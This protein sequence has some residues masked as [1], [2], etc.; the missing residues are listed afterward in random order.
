MDC[1]TKSRAR[2]IPRVFQDGRP[3]PGPLRS[4]EYPKGLPNLAGKDLERVRVDNQ[5]CAFVLDAIEEV[6][7]RGGGSIR[8]NP[9]G[10]STGT[11]H[12]SSAWPVPGSTAPAALGGARCQYQR[13]QH[14]IEE[15]TEWPPAVCHH[16]HLP[17]E[18]EPQLVNGQRVY[19]SK[20]EAEYT[21]PVAFCLAVATS[22]WA[23]RRGLAVLKVPTMPRPPVHGQ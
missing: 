22:W 7:E 5:A 15:V 1:S 3:A 2:E 9:G 13:L 17:T 11:S 4:E 10:P 16:T 6:V 14:N 12:K 21:A 23:A 19:P 20:E 8:E 18:W